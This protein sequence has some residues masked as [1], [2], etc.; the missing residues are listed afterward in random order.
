MKSQLIVAIITSLPLVVGCGSG[1]SG[2]VQVFVE[3]EDT[4]P[5]GLDP[6]DGEE[7]IVDGWRVEYTRFLAVVGN[8]RAGQSGDASAAL[9]D[10]AVYVV[11][12]LNLPVG[13]FVMTEF[14]DVDAVRWDR[15]G[16]DLPNATDVAEPADGTAA[17]DRDFMVTGG[18]SLYIEGK[19]LKADGQSCL[20]TDPTDCQ[21][22]PEVRFA[23][24]LAAGTSYDDCAPQTGDAG[25]AVPSGGTAQVKP[26]I[27][28]D[29]WFFTNITQGAEI[30]ERRA[31]WVADADLDRDGETTLDELKQVKAADLF[32]SEL[33]YTVTGAQIPVITAHD[34]LEAQVRTL[35]DFQGEGE[36]PTRRIL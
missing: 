15:V 4:I 3:A 20:P 27:H 5:E 18:Y 14:D 6:G 34:Y 33:G 12:L 10:P 25:F 11:D 28:G 22:A 26:T 2:R 9:V 32:R 13:G 17:A 16:Y 31:Q 24:G 1:A 7:D 36:C 21:P 23:W 29:H 8:F 19:L 30:T 35:G